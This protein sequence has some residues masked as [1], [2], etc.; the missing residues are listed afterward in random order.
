M[1]VFG[2]DNYLRRRAPCFVPYVGTLRDERPL[3]PG[4]LRRYVNEKM[5]S[6]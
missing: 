5:P 6:P 4:A 2:G 3:P 1:A